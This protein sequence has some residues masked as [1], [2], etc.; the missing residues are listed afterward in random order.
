MI[1]FKC[2]RLNATMRPEACGRKYEQIQTGSI[3]SIRTYGTASEIGQCRDCPIGKAHLKGK[4][5][6]GV[7]YSERDVSAASPIAPC[8]TPKVKPVRYPPD[9]ACLQARRM[10]RSLHGE[11]KAS[12]L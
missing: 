5:A 8:A 12:L 6:R 2:D 4:K 7:T 3:G 9:R 10:L 1:L 11:G